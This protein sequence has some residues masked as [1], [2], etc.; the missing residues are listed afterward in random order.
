M[1]GS[2]GLK[3]KA[4]TFVFSYQTPGYNPGFEQLSPMINQGLIQNFT[5]FSSAAL[6]Q[7]NQPPKYSKPLRQPEIDLRR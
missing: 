6:G 7:N 2:T 3:K 4:V 5:S 1:H